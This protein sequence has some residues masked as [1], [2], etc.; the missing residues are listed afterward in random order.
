MSILQKQYA[1]DPQA[2]YARDFPQMI[3]R[4]GKGDRAARRESG[5][6]RR[7]CESGDLR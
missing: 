6:Q 5:S 4:G 2:G 3:E 7:W 1:R